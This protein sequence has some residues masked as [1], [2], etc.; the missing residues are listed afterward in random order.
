MND[1]DYLKQRFVCDGS[2][3]TL[4]WRPITDGKS[5]SEIKRWNSSFAG[6]EAGCTDSKGYKIVHLNNKTYK[7]HRIIWAISTGEMPKGFIDHINHNRSDNRLENLRVVTPAESAQNRSKAK[8]NTSKVTGVR[9]NKA[10]KCWVANIC[11]MGKAVH[12]GNFKNMEDAI[13]ARFDGET[14]YNFHPNHGAE[15]A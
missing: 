14:K 1:I 5:P 4:V 10:D 15:A 3:G 13:R 7:V 9:W 8:N 11:V 6:K 2:A 12:L